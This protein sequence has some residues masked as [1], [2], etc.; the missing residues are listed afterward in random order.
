MIRMTATTTTTLG[1]HRL[2][3][4]SALDDDAKD[5]VRSRTLLVEIGG[6]GVLSI[7]SGGQE[8][9][10]LVGTRD[11]LFLESPHDDT[12]VLTLEDPYRVRCGELR[13]GG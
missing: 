10:Y 1:G 12:L 5:G 11:D 9:E 3:P 8:R 4:L 2:P 6:T 7:V 13:R